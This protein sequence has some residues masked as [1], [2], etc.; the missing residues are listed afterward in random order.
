MPRP[1]GSKNKK[2]LEFEARIGDFIAEK[3]LEQ[4]RLERQMEGVQQEIKERSTA[5]NKL[6][7]QHRRVTREMEELVSRRDALDSA[8]SEMAKFQEVEARVADLIGKGVS[9]DQLLELLKL[10]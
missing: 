4:K 8:A 3:L 7:T 1:K 10:S 5:L 6:R 2:T 9:A